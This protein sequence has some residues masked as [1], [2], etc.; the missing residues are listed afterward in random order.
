MNAVNRVVMVILLLVAMVLCSVL[1]VFP[2]RSL[3]AVAR[4][5]TAQADFI[6]QFE[7]LSPD[8]FVRVG[9]GSVLALVLD[10]CFLLLI[11]L[12]VRRPS[13]K[14]IRVQ[15]AAGGEVQI[16]VASIAD[17]L[18]YEVDQLASVLRTKPKVSGKRGGVVVELDVETAAGIN[19]PEKSGQILGT[20]QRVVEEGMGLKLARPPKV[21]L[22]V[23]RHPKV[24]KEKAPVLPED[25]EEAVP[26]MP[27]SAPEEEPP[28]LPEDFW[29]P[30]PSVPA[31]EPSALPDDAEGAL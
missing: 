31:E 28:V 20:A 21:N 1:L 9:L 14:A 13:R 12:E 16:S 18:R 24:P 17:R 7:R 26:S 23:V 10:V 5:S 6:R 30:L 27:P 3:D 19:V 22:R 11:I 25:V 8:W 4:W 29:E 2:V 15:K